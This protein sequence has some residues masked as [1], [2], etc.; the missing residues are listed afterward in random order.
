M[1][2]FG[3]LADEWKK[4]STGE[5]IMIGGGVIGVIAIALYIHNQSTQQ[6]QPNTAST[7]ADLTGG[8]GGGGIQTVPGPNGS[9][10]PI[11]PGGLCQ[12]FDQQGNLTGYVP[13]N[14][15]P[16]PTPTPAPAPA[17]T[18][19]CPKGMQLCNGK[20]QPMGLLCRNEINPK[21]APNKTPG[22]RPE[23]GTH[24]AS[25]ARTVPNRTQQRT[26]PVVRH[27]PPRQ[28]TVVAHVASQRH[29]PRAH[30]GSFG[31]PSKFPAGGAFQYQNTPYGSGYGTVNGIPLT[32]P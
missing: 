12:Q 25:S 6:A 15:T 20:C 27:A 11:L 30:P 9:Q 24:H 26:P 10:L 19:K 28:H 2:W 4:A 18:G 14:P 3:D 22:Q 17:P 8:G 21:H 5:K 31:S 23:K 13:C 29:T 1:G 32:P 16:T 7:G